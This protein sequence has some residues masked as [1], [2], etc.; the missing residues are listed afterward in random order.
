[1]KCATPFYAR[2]ISLLAV[3]SLI[4]YFSGCSSEMNPLGPDLSKTHQ[5]PDNQP[6]FETVQIDEGSVLEF[7]PIQNGP[8]AGMEILSFGDVVPHLMKSLNARSKISYEKGGKLKIDTKVPILIDNETVDMDL[9]VELKIKKK[10]IDRDS[11]DVSMALDSDQ[12]LSDLDVLFGPHGLNFS[13]PA[14]LKIHV[15][16][17]DLR[18]LGST[19]LFV[20]YYNE[21]SCA[22]EKME[23]KKIHI[24]KE[25]DGEIRVEKAKL[26]HF[27]RYALI[28]G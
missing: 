8:L 25:K 16:H 17:I 26:P 5:K 22:W 12:F 4:I 23:V 1:M 20:Y 21:V 13:E 2:I 9:K 19:D 18:K 10:T 7:K 24:K 15:K 11:A 28:K 14:E 3:F 27:S 6:G